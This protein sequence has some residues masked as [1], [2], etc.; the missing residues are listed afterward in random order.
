[1]RH[2]RQFIAHHRL[3]PRSRWDV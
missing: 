3:N 1:V 2:C